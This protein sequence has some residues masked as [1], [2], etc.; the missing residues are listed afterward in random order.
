MK[1]PSSDFAVQPCSIDDVSSMLRSYRDAFEHDPMRI[2]GTGA[3]P[4]SVVQEWHEERF[5]RRFTAPEKSPGVFH[6]KAVETKSGM[7]AGF[8]RFAFPH[9]ERRD[10]N[11]KKK[12]KKPVMD[13]E[14]DENG[15]EDFFSTLPEGANVAALKESFTKLSAAQ[16]RHYNPTT[17]YAAELIVTDPKYQ[18]RGIATMLCRH[19]LDMADK[20]GA[21]TYV[22]ATRMGEPVYERLGWKTV[23]VV[24][25]GLDEERG[26]GRTALEV[27]DGVFW[28]MVREPQPVKS[29]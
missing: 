15:A 21:R 23:E 2:W 6:Y 9:E 29:G 24:T 16:K 26:D 4:D 1:M 7:L 27:R 3:I 28:I 10:E 22:E 19:V 17:D 5:S 20:D 18:R 11:G 8:G 25:F 12:E 14:A 13:D